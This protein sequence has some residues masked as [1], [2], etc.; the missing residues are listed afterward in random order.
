VRVAALV[1]LLCAC[2][3]QSVP[4][5]RVVEELAE[6]PM[7]PQPSVVRAWVEARPDLYP[8]LRAAPAVGLDVQALSMGQDLGRW[9]RRDTRWG[10]TPTLEL[11]DTDRRESWVPPAAGWLQDGVGR[12]RVVVLRDFLG[13]P[14]AESVEALLPSILS[15]FPAPWEGCET[16][17]GGTLLHD[18]ARGIALYLARAKVGEGT[19]PEGTAPEGTAPERTA[20]EGSDVGDGAVV[21]ERIEFFPTVAAWE[22]VLA[23]RG[24]AG[25]TPRFEITA[26][27]SLVRSPR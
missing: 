2:P 24:V 21:V 22:D 7:G 1:A 8:A 3:R 27:G 20:P 10:S 14:R 13:S 11:L 19:A 5:P 4:L 15:S 6:P 12:V 26:D 9:T 17:S 18:S 16:P 23:F 25:C